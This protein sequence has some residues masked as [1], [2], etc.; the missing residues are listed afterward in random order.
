MRL[1]LIREEI[2]L[3]AESLGQTSLG[4]E[5][6]DM[7]STSFRLLPMG[8]TAYVKEIIG[9]SNMDKRYEKLFPNLWVNN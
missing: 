5:Y 2:D 8:P 6:H 3:A 9:V 7:M 1:C 4:E